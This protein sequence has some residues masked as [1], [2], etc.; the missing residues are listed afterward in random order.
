MRSRRSRHA[1][2]YVYVC[3][4]MRVYL[5]VYVHAIFVLCYVYVYVC[6]CMCVFA[7]CVSVGIESCM[8]LS[9]CGFEWMVA[10]GA[11]VCGWGGGCVVFTS[12]VYSCVCVCILSIC[13]AI[14]KNFGEEAS[15]MDRTLSG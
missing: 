7:S 9:V 6:M 14:G 3:F 15:P 5:Y 8:C 1:N 2:V 4:C 13:T 11:Y 12:C 10:W